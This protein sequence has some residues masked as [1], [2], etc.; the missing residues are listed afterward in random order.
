MASFE[1]RGK[2]WRAVISVTDIK[3]V[4]KKSTKTFD[5]KKEAAIWATDQESKSNNGFNILSG[6]TLFPDYFEEWVEIYKRPIIRE[7]TYL[8]YKTWIIAVKKI[9]NG[10]ELNKLSNYQLQQIINT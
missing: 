1:K 4:R 3:G 5:T 6:K 7:S 10:I 2:K 8:R 9:F